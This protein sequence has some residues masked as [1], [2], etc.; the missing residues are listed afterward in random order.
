MINL[1]NLSICVVLSQNLNFSFISFFFIY[2]VQ[3]WVMIV[4]IGDKGTEG[5]VGRFVCRM[6]VAM[7]SILRTEGVT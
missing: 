6:G 3:N 1:S 4:T 7:E 5:C 2:V